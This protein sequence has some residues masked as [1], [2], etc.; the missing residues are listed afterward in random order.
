MRLRVNAI[1][2]F[3]SLVSLYWIPIRSYTGFSQ[4]LD[5]WTSVRIFEERKREKNTYSIKNVIVVF[6]VRVVR[7]IDSPTWALYS[8]SLTPFDFVAEEVI[9]P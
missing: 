6:Y 5:G 1:L 7:A 3:F 8:L 9:G 4:K 2:V